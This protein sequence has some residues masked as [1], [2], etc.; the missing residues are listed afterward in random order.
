[1]H[2]P[3]I[4][5]LAGWL[6]AMETEISAALWIHVAW[7]GFSVIYVYSAPSIVMSMSVCLSVSPHAYLGE[8]RQNCTKFSVRVARGPVSVLLWRSCN[9]LRT[10]GFVDDVSFLIMDPL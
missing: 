6:G 8:T 2:Y 7:K 1:M 4:R 3:R 5:G 9:M 10:S